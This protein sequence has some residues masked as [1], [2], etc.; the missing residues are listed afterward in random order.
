MSSIIEEDFNSYD[1]GDLNG[2]GDWSGSSDFD[3]QGDVVKEGAKA[4]EFTAQSTPA[5]IFKTGTTTTD[6]K[7]GVYL[8]V[9][10]AYPG[11]SAMV[12][13]R[14]GA[15]IVGA[16]GM[17]NNEIR[18]LGT[19]SFTTLVTDYTLGQWY[20][21][22]ME[23]RSS[24]DK[25]RFRVDD[26]TWTDWENKC[27]NTAADPDRVDLIIETGGLGSSAVAYFDYISESAFELPEVSEKVFGVIF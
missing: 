24:D 14:G 9:D 21:V 26:G 8:R 7:I 25:M 16:F 27:D 18:Y 12:Y 13:I 2:Q 5:V 6:G 3:V 19:S 10:E 17:R 23:W 20:F 22:Q 11:G 15:T 1:D 4:V